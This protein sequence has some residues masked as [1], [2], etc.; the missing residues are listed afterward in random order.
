MASLA[1]EKN[2]NKYI[3]IY[4]YIY[5]YIQVY[6]YMQIEIERERE[7]RERERAREM[8]IRYIRQKFRL[9]AFGIVPNNGNHMDQTMENDKETPIL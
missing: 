9:R 5:T 6:I 1:A 3:Y 2:K 7:R 4:I 8:N